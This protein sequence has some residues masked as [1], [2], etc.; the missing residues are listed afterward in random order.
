MPIRRARRRHSN[1]ATMAVGA[2]SRP[3]PGRDTRMPMRCHP[4]FSAPS[5]ILI[6]RVFAVSLAVRAGTRALG[7]RCAPLHPDDPRGVIRSAISKARRQHVSKRPQSCRRLREYHRSVPALS[8]SD[9]SRT[10]PIRCSGSR[11]SPVDTLAPLLQHVLLLA[12]PL[13]GNVALAVP[14]QAAPCMPSDLR[15]RRPPGRRLSLPQ[16]LHWTA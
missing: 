5:S 12:R 3:T 6:S 8:S 10:A 9:A 4:L 2:T 16:G 13:R 15:S 11:S 1:L 7:A 14:S